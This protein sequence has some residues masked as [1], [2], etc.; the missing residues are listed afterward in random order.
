MKACVRPLFLNKA[1]N[2]LSKPR[3]PDIKVM[4]NIKSK[5]LIAWYVRHRLGC[6]FGP[7]VPV[8]G[9][10]F[11]PHLRRVWPEA[12]T[13]YEGVPKKKAQQTPN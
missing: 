6:E 13:N 12:K 11:G 10:E 9:R 7:L 4:R 3:N 8:W 5:R 1:N 2:P